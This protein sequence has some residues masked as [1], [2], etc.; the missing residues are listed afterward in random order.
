MLIYKA[1]RE[2]SGESQPANTL[3]LNFIFQNYEKINF[4][5]FKIP[6]YG[7]LLQQP[8]QTNSLF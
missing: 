3:I 6:V 5:C 2:V 1:R 4:H 8:K 7:I